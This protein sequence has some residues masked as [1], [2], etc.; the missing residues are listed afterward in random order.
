MSLVPENRTFNPAKYTY[1]YDLQKEIF[2]WFRGPGY[3][4]WLQSI[5]LFSEGFYQIQ[6]DWCFLWLGLLRVC[7]LK[8]L[9]LEVKCCLAIQ[10]PSPEIIAFLYHAIILAAKHLAPSR[11][12]IH[13]TGSLQNSLTD[14]HASAVQI[15]AEWPDSCWLPHVLILTSVFAEFSHR[16]MA[17]EIDDDPH[18]RYDS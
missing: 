8:S 15:H 5:Y 2:N 18:S 14:S 4:L 11:S 10:F 13:L 16:K 17:D 1:F 9:E 7:L 12:L 3:I 6:P